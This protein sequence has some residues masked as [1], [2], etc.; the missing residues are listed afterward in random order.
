LNSQKAVSIAL[1]FAFCGR[2]DPRKYRKL[3]A[4]INYLGFTNIRLIHGLLVKV[5]YYEQYACSSIEAALLKH[6]LL[7]YM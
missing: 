2:K 7:P 1:G 3:Q 4:L 5:H 6:S